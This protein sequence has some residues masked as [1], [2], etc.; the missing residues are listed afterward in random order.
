MRWGKV[1]TNNFWAKAIS[2]ALAVATWFYVFDVVNTD[3]YLQ[4]EETAEEIF[5]RYKFVVKEIPVKPVFAGKSPE[6][7]R[8]AFEKV[9]IE[10]SK[11]SV[12]GPQEVIEEVEE[13]RTDKINL[14]EYTRSVR[15]QLGLKSDVKFL[16]F[17]DK[18][19]DVYVPV[20]PV[21]V[22]PQQ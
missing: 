16:Q 5:A 15:L 12:F 13:L 10:P 7:Y 4:K 21:V 19:V 1:I 11:V 3:S 8:V 9:I 6:G 2:L 17:E 14:G 20:E 22:E 18:V